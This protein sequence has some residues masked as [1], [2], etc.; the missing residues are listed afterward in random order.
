MGGRGGR[1]LECHTPRGSPNPWLVTT[2]SVSF[3]APG[4]GGKLSAPPPGVP[5]R[6]A[7][8]ALERS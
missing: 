5:G 8:G 3:L 6:S 4:G 7:R 2:A 1:T